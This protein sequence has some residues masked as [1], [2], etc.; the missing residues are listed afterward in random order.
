M[1]SLHLFKILA[2]LDQLFREY[3]QV[4][5]HTDSRIIHHGFIVFLCF[6][7]LLLQQR[8]HHFLLL[9][10]VLAQGLK[11]RLAFFGEAALVQDLFQLGYVEC[12]FFQDRDPIQG[13]LR[14]DITLK[15]VQL[16]FE[17]GEH[18]LESVL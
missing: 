5:M 14:P 8:L 16:D 18:R 10:D 7:K 13:L 11:F 9:A 4:L 17:F 1:V 3:V 12:R 6:V 15:L 2:E